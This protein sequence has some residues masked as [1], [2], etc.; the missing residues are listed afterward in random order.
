MNFIKIVG[1]NSIMEGMGLSPGQ[2]GLTSYDL[3]SKK[4]HF[5]YIFSQSPISDPNRIIY[6][7]LYSFGGT[8]RMGFGWQTGTVNPEFFKQIQLNMSPSSTLLKFLD[9]KQIGKELTDYTAF[10]LI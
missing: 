5:A 6:V 2:D 7:T 1:H 3:L 10:A 9:C 8:S 4:H